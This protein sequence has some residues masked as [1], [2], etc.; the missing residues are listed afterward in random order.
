MANSLDSVTATTKLEKEASEVQ[1]ALEQKRK[2]YRERMD[3]VKQREEQLKVKRAELQEKLITF[4]K[5]IQDN[6]LKRNR[7]N[8]KAAAEEKAKQERHSQIVELSEK[9]KRLELEKHQSREKYQRYV[10]YEK[11]LTDVLQHG[12]NEEYQDA[13]GIIQR[14]Q[15]LEDNKKMLQKRKTDLE[16]ELEKRKTSLSLKRQRKKNDAVELQNQLSE[17]NTKLETLQKNF[18][19]RQDEL[20]ASIANKSNTTTI[21]GQVRM[22]CQN[23]YDKC[24]ADNTIYKARASHADA[25]SEAQ[26]ITAQL[27]VIGDCLLDYQSV[28]Q[29]HKEKQK[30]KALQQ[31][32]EPVAATAK[33]SK[34]SDTAKATTM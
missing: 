9:L 2:E 24:V 6:E 32:A 12:D 34:P 11:Y 1:E 5:F 7:A 26:L 17:L 20:D 19:K 27:Q 13:N 16:T 21:I 33:K 25:D 30:E 18:K 15:T 8:K 4:Y 14:W 10:K 28:I 23:L 3:Q 31:Q 22:A 29:R